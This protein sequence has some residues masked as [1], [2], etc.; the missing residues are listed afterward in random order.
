MMGASYH[1]GL[2]EMHPTSLT[3]CQMETVHNGSVTA[4]ELLDVYEA[5]TDIESDKNESD[6][7]K[8]SGI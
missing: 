3:A 2:K 4:H 8:C 1:S 5:D 7:D 6:D